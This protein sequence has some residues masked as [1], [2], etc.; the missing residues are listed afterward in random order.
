MD[1]YPEPLVYLLP[2][3]PSLRNF[4][5]KLT[6]S[7]IAA[8]L[9]GAVPSLAAPL[10]NL[11]RRQS[12]KVTI[13]EPSVPV[14]NVTYTSPKNESLPTVVIFATGG[15]IAGSS[16]SATDTTRY[17]AGVVGVEALIRGEQ[18]SPN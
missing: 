8:G 1:G 4:S 15:T 14:L 12:S 6:S 9:L 13:S 18:E 5:M 16:S 11:D 10:V 17:T 2:S 3:Y 7:L